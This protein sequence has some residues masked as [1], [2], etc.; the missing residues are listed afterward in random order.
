MYCYVSDLLSRKLKE[1][2]AT[3]RKCSINPVT[4]DPAHLSVSMTIRSLEWETPGCR[5]SVN[6]GENDARKHRHKDYIAGKRFGNKNYPFFLKSVI[7]LPTSTCTPE[8]H[9]CQDIDCRGK[10]L[11]LLKKSKGIVNLN[12]VT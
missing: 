10:S 12:V 3:S 9:Y 7:C 6:N 2:I 11:H 4:R 5:A 1:Q 8:G